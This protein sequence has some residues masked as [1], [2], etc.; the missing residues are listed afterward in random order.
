VTD[1]IHPAA[2]ERLPRDAAVVKVKRLA[3]TLQYCALS[4]PH[5]AQPLLFER[6]YARHFV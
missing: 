4:L 5:C 3:E 6:W 1:E 2:G